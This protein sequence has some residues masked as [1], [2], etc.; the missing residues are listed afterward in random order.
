MTV[1]VY[2][3][4]TYYYLI[5]LIGVLAKTHYTI[6]IPECSELMEKVNALKMALEGVCTEDLPTTLPTTEQP[7]IEPLCSCPINWTSVPFTEIGTTNLKHA[8]TL[9]FNIPSVVPSSATE[10]LIHA[11][12]Y[13]GSSNNGP[14]QYIKIFT[15]IGTAKYEKYLMM[16]SYPQ[17]AINTNSDNMWFPMPPNRR[18]YLTLQTAVGNNAAAYLHTIG[19]R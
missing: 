1:S 17:S 3:Y 8:A 15:Q 19:Y 14:L 9:S 18:V 7:T 11:G 16:F 6:I 10:V 4:H 13:T 2:T 12:F 5:Y